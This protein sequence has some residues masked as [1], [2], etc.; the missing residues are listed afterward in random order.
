MDT[1]ICLNVIEHIEDDHNA[2]KNI[3]SILKTGGTA[4]ILVPH[5]PGIFGTLD[6]VLGHYRRYTNSQLQKLMEGANFEVR[7]I[8]EFNRISRPAW[9]MN[10]KILKRKTITRSQLALFDSLVGL[11]RKIDSYI[12]WPPTSI[13]AIGVKKN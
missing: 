7:E 12:P 5:G 6:V 3:N 11:W 2:M 13:I 4:I 1:V 8:I 9:F 10:G